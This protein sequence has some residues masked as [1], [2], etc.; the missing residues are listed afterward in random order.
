[1][2]FILL[3]LI[4]SFFAYLKIPLFLLELE[5]T[6]DDKTSFISEAKDEAT[7]EAQEASALPAGYIKCQSG[8]RHWHV[9]GVCGIGVTVRRGRPVF[10]PQG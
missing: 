1:M 3:L 8:R 5:V 2:W 7:S 4:E 9:D 10:C 6:L